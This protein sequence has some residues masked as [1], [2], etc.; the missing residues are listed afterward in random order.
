[1]NRRKPR[2]NKSWQAMKNNAQGHFFEG[3]ISGACGYYKD[4]GRAIVEKIPEPF[5]TTGTGRDG[6]FTG[7]FIANAQPD[8]MGTLR[9][10]QAI[11]F[12]A[13]YTS[14]DRILQ[15]VITKTQWD[16]LERHWAAGAMAGVC[17]GIGDVFGFVP[18]GTW[19]KMKE[20][21]GHKYMTAADLEAFRVKFNGHCLFLDYKSELAQEEMAR[22]ADRHERQV[23]LEA[24]LGEETVNNQNKRGGNSPGG[25]YQFRQPVPGLKRGR[26]AGRAFRVPF[27]AIPG[28]G[29]D[30]TGNEG[31]DKWRIPKIYYLGKRGRGFFEQ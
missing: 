19:R 1:M 20:I 8:F 27:R 18:W 21:Y 28:G 22:L 24:V 9:G 3:Y 13:K 30:Y 10:G 15:S 6:T 5:R 11:C 2:T 26:E 7:R 12:E 4:T 25:H 29:A 17:V 16:S 31:R 14:T 23:K